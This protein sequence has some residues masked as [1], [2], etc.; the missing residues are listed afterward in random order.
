MERCGA[1]VEPLSGRRCPAAEVG[2]RV[3]ARARELRELGVRPGD[4]VLLHSGNTIEFFLD[5]LAVWWLGAAA[6]PVDARLTAFELGVLARAARPRLSLWA[7]A[8]GTDVEQAL[9]GAGARVVAGGGPQRAQGDTPPPGV[10]TLDGEALVLFTSGT[11]GDPKGVV[12]THRS[13]RAQWTSLAHVH[14]REPFARTLCLLPTHFGHGLICNSLFPWLGGADLHL[15]PPF[16]PDVAAGLGALVDEHAITFLSS[17]PSFWRLALRVGRP[18][19]GGSLEQVF[20]GSAP[21]SAA[22]WEQIADWT[23]ARVRNAYGITETASWVA[24]TTVDGVAPEDGLVGV[25]WGADVAIMADA[26]AAPGGGEERPAGEEGLVWLRTPALMR[27]YLDR[28]DLTDAVVSQG[29][30][31]TGDVGVVDERGLLLLRGRL[32]EEINKGGLKVYPGD[33]DGVVE[34]FAGVVDACAFAVDDPLLGQDVA[35]AVVVDGP[36]DGTLAA[37]RAW[38]PERLARHQLPVRWYVLDEIPR[39]SRGKVNRAD[40]AAVCAGLR[41]AGRE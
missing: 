40:V 6:V 29:W 3:A 23:G 27:G 8:P 22:L 35:V 15:L 30:F 38:L 17:V 7:D 41:P 36:P 39:T 1:L 9:A 13:L 11:T 19:V 24:G 16:R 25:P 20:C 2:P 12:H 32:R 31:S 18:P 33:V 26:A 21:L 34:Q 37:L 5:L 14:G 4:R 28:P 10:L